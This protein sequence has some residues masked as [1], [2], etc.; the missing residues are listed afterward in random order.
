MFS[1]PLCPLGREARR[2]SEWHRLVQTGLDWCAFFVQFFVQ[3]E[4]FPVFPEPA[5]E[6]R[7]SQ[8]T[9]AVRGLFVI[10]GYRATLC[11]T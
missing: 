9:A 5:A 1:L 6:T 8:S 2:I 4:V 10:L 11:D 7:T 3:R